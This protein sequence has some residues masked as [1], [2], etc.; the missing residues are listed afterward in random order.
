M[1]SAETHREMR[2]SG[3]SC[4]KTSV[5]FRRGTPLFKPPPEEFHSLPPRPKI[6]GS[7]KSSRKKKNQACH[8]SKNFGA[9]GITS[10]HPLR[11]RNRKIVQIPL[12]AWKI[13]V[14]MRTVTAMIVL[15]V[16]IRI[17]AISRSRRADWPNTDGTES[18]I[19]RT[20]HEECQEIPPRKWEIENLVVHGPLGCQRLPSCRPTA[21]SS[22]LVSQISGFFTPFFY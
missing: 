20:L 6:S 1:P 2:S 7:T 3:L 4:H 18:L 8:L 13:R 5:L 15:T 10:V 19:R 14:Q 21:I 12:E 17:G 16:L 9:L 22:I 11:K